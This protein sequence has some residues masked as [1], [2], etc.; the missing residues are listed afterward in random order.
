MT[1]VVTFPTRPKLDLT[2]LSFVHEYWVRPPARKRGMAFRVFWAVSP[3]G[4]RSADV[5]AGRQMALEWLRVVGGLN[6]GPVLLGWIVKD[7]P[8]DLTG[9]EIGFLC[10]IGLV[11]GTNPYAEQVIRLR[12][13]EGKRIAAAWD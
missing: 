13:E 12:E 2:D 8:R 9:L 7:M 10:T 5:E 4:D 6:I 1:N 11:A 3:S